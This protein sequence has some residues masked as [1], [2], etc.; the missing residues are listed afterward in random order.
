MGNLLDRP[1]WVYVCYAADDEILYIGAT[2]DL[3][4]RLADH[5]YRKPW[6]R[7]VVRVQEYPMETLREAR[8]RERRAIGSISPPHNTHHKHCGEDGS[9]TSRAARRG[10]YHRV[11][12]PFLPGSQTYR[13][14]RL[15]DLADEILAALDPPLDR[16]PA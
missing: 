4:R 13:L 3:E 16:Q 9:W 6:W 2:C 11:G 15:S 12:R 10:T 7:E 14:E 5:R 8:E 1:G